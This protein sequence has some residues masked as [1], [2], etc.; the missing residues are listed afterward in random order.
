MVARD[1]TVSVGG[2]CSSA[3]VPTLRVFRDASVPMIIAL[4]NSTDLLAPGYDSVFLLPGTVDDE[5]DFALEW[6]PR[7]GGRRLA[8]IHDGTS[9]PLT[10]A[11]ATAT[12]ARL[13]G[14]PVTLTTEL[15]LSQG[16]SNYARIA[17]AVVAGGADIVYFTGYYAEGNRLIVDLR[18]RGFAGPVLVG[19][20]AADGPLLENL[21]VEQHR[22]VYGTQLLVPGFMPEIADW[23]KR[24]E[25]MS[26][27]PPGL[28]TVEAY[29]AVTLALDAIRRAGNLDRGAVRA[30]IAATA[31]LD[32]LSGPALFNA[33]GTRTNPK[34]LMLRVRP[35]GFDP[36]PLPP[37]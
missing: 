33:N 22:D 7:L 3:T 13:P 27:A 30:A 35:G 4:S 6:M 28:C 2:Y 19:D 18:E 25:A 9:F 10:L 12:A 36:V 14:S 32:L 26:G 11:Q 24:F 23:A 21:T 16:A 17:E 5:A 20:G 34:F 29:D 8:V 1:I 31:Q 37:A 15:E